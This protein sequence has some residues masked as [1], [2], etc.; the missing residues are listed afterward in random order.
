MKVT[1]H[2]WFDKDREAAIR[3]YTS[4]IPGSSVGWVSAVPADTPSG[5]AGSV[6]IA[7]FTLGDQ[8]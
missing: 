7:G 2:L 1:Q 3:F 4:L 6:K 8:R 5:P